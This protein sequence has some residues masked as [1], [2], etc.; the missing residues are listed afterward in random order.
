M[1]SFAPVGLLSLIA[2]SRKELGLTPMLYDLNRRIISQDI[3]LDETF[4]DNVAVDILACNPDVV[5]FMTE[6]DSYHHVLQTC[7]HIKKISPKVIIVLGGPHASAVAKKTMERYSAIDAVC[8]GEAEGSFVNYLDAISNSRFPAVAGMV[9]R[10]T[11]GLAVEGPPNNLVVTLDSLPAPA[12]DLYRPDEDEEIFVEV[13]R[14]CPFHCTF[15][16]TSVFWKRQHRVKSPSRIIHE[17]RWIASLYGAAR[18]V[19]FTHD[20]FTT[21]RRWVIQVCNALVDAQ[22]GVKWTCS[23]RTDTVDRDLLN[24]MYQA[25]CDAIYF[26]IESGSARILEMIH[27]DIP[28]RHSLDTLQLCRGIGIQANCGFILGFPGEDDESIRDTFSAYEAAL[29]MGSKPAHIFGFCPFKDSAMFDTLGLLT[30]NGHFLDIP[31]PESL[32]SINRRLIASDETLYGS[33]FRVAH[34]KL[35]DQELLLGIDEFSPL[36]ESALAPTLALASQIGGMHVVYQRWVLWIRAQNA[37]RNAKRSRRCYGSPV[38]FC[39]FLI[40]ELMASCPSQIGPQSLARL[41]R[42]NLKYASHVNRDEG[43]SMASHRSIQ[44]PFHYGGVSAGTVLYSG[45][46]FEILELPCD[47]TRWLLEPLNFTFPSSMPIEP[48]YFVWSTAGDRVRLLRISAFAAQ[49][50]HLVETGPVSVQTILEHSQT[51]HQWDID[52]MAAFATLT[53]AVSEGLL[54]ANVDYESPTVF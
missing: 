31:L 8:L 18:R 32:D 54:R 16:S 19:H 4:Y 53:E 27:K 11:R 22:L 34:K 33:Y 17:L 39:D 38:Q 25:G 30:C 43:L 6:C 50:L 23:A 37:K 9:A 21:D 2:N 13:G 24:L 36:V 29:R 48:T 52:Q 40:E 3:V 12:Y 1:Y 51:Q 14:G 35:K 7:Q 10:D 26:G 42:A 41:L 46:V 45:N 5:G 44:A 15:C 47:V 28:V 49:A 20:L